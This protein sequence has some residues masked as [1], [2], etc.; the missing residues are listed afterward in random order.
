MGFNKMF[1]KC[2]MAVNKEMKNYFKRVRK[3]LNKGVK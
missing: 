2:G 1:Y 3:Q